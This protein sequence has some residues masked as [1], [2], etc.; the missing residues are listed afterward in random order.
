[1]QG[2]RLALETPTHPL[3]KRGAET[4]LAVVPAC[5]PNPGSAATGG[6]ADE[7]SIVTP[8]SRYLNISRGVTT[9]LNISAL[10]MRTTSSRQVL[11]SLCSLTHKS[12]LRDRSFLTKNTQNQ[13]RREHHLSSGFHGLRELC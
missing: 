5:H 8:T 6:C 3:A 10:E 7:A 4:D 12:A 1:M 11:Q 13:R 9:M 2:S